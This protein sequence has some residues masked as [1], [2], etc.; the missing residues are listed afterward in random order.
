[1]LDRENEIINKY[2]VSLKENISPEI[3]LEFYIYAPSI[4]LK[5]TYYSFDSN[6]QVTIF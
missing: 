6:N 1:M 4:T 5:N 2:V 3:K